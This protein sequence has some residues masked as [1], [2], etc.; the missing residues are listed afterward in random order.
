MLHLDT[1][2]EMPRYFIFWN[3]ALWADCPFPVA[4]RLR[5]ALGNSKIPRKA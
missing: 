2:K 1:A 4:N 3:E 5:R